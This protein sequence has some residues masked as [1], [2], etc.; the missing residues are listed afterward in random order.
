MSSSDLPKKHAELIDRFV[1]TASENA[2]SASHDGDGDG[3]SKR[4]KILADS[5]DSNNGGPLT[6]PEAR[7]GLGGDDNLY[8]QLGMS[9]LHTA[10]PERT[11]A[12]AALY[13]A[14]VVHAIREAIAQN[15]MAELKQ[16]K[17]DAETKLPVVLANLES[18][19][20]D[21]SLESSLLE[22]AIPR[23]KALKT[24]NANFDPKTAADVQKLKE[25][26]EDVKQLLDNEVANEIE[27]QFRSQKYLAIAAAVQAAAAQAQAAAANPGGG[28][29]GINASVIDYVI[30]RGLCGH[31]GP[32]EAQGSCPT[33]A[34]L[35]YSVPKH[36]AKTLAR[37]ASLQLPSS[38]TPA[39]HT[40]TRSSEGVD[41]AVA[42]F[43]S[44][45]AIDD[46]LPASD[47]RGVV[48]AARQVRWQPE[49][50]HA[51]ALAH[52]AAL[53]HAIARCKQLLS[54][55]CSALSDAAKRELADAAVC[56]KL[57]QIDSLHELACA[58]E[59]G[60]VLHHA[61]SQTLVTRPVATIRG[62]THLAHDA[63]HHPAP[64]TSTVLAD[65]RW[66]REH[67]RDD[68]EFRRSNKTKFNV[69]KAP[70]VDELGYLPVVTSAPARV[71]YE[72]EPTNDARYVENGTI[73][74]LK[75]LV[76][77]GLYYADIP[78][79]AAVKTAIQSA[80]GA[81]GA[82]PIG[83]AESRRSGI[84]NEMLRDI[85]VSTDRLW[86]FVRTLSGLIGDDADGLLVTADEATAA[87][88][89]DLQAQR[90]ATADRVAAFQGR[91]IESLVGSMMRESG[92]RLDTNAQDA[93]EALVVVNKETAKQINDL[94]SGESGRPF[95]EANVALRALADRGNS[96]KHKLGK[97]V[98]QVNGVV[99]ELH[100]ALDAELQSPATA[101]ASLAELSAPRNSYFVKLRD[102]CTAAIRSSFDKFTVECSVKGVGRIALWELVEGAD[103]T[104]CTRFAEL[105]GHVLVQNRTSTGVAALY[106]N[107]QQLLV[108]ASQAQVAL[109]R[110]INHGGHY[111]SSYPR[112]DF[113]GP[114][115][116]DLRT[117]RKAYFGLHQ[118]QAESWVGSAAAVAMRYARER[119]LKHVERVARPGDTVAPNL[120]K[121]VHG[122]N[123]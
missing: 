87:A 114:G 99:R 7:Y 113:G 57:R 100:Q 30:A 13:S 44:N 118:E 45:Y 70:A 105:V 112:P 58:A 108:N 68:A 101:G 72:I 41:E 37:C 102:D 59:D 95:F 10:S 21:G 117:L 29:D 119:H 28:I 39:E 54:D 38:A 104:L 121:W 51:F 88:A 62:T 69:Y 15:A 83:T 103:H 3:I 4:Q 20:K 60:E 120:R 52:A 81:S 91:L 73:K 40:D 31:R 11:L 123:Y 14:D 84:W 34:L 36:L 16:R 6:A 61:P 74:T 93:A 67:V 86:T 32:A 110:L 5:H 22:F 77:Y 35:T 53:E 63:G 42:A 24:L 1:G 71:E 90:K 116:T 26:L 27:L 46:D 111:R 78:E 107:R 43:A 65:Q 23:S 18:I 47:E 49:G 106:A 79:A 80:S 75:E 122:T 2:G 76:A 33:D 64:S 96:G 17:K 94:A 25:I 50:E 12:P 97:V 89:R 8:L 48:C 55:S 115:T 82:D 9:V 19:F 98:A 92:L 56:L 66:T 85:A 109:Q